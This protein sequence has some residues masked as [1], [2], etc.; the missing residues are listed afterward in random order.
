MLI[1]SFRTEITDLRHHKN[2]SVAE[3]GTRRWQRFT[4]IHLHFVQLLCW[5]NIV[6][7]I[8]IMR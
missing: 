3:F 6:Y 7:V 2:L 8:D 5:A 4:G 1:F